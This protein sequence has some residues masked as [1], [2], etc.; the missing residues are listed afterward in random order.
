MAFDIPPEFRQFVDTAIS[1]GAFTSESDVVG[2]ALRLL[3]ER[4]HRL[5][6]LRNEIRPAL[7]RL[8]RGEGIELDDRS[9]DKFF[10]DLKARGGSRRE[11]PETRQ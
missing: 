3:Q 7:E 6:G 1:S 4:Q 2:A 10:E 11:A 9:L 8:D 5:D